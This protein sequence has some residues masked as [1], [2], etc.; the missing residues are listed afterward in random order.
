[1]D[2]ERRRLTLFDLGFLVAAS[3]LAM[4][5]MGW[6]YLDVRWSNLSETW[7][8]TL[9][10][11]GIAH[12][13]LAILA[14]EVAYLMPSILALCICLLALRLRHPRPRRWRRIWSQPGMLAC[15]VIILVAIES[16]AIFTLQHS[17][18]L[19]SRTLPVFT[20]MWPVEQTGT[21]IVIVW[22]TLGLTGRWR[23]ERSWID[24]AGRG[25]ALLVVLGALCRGLELF[26]G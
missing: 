23:P 12:G 11:Y 18:A 20:E 2:P 9:K 3:G 17:A 6:L 4:A 15:A 21:A 14:G 13:I 24:R 10:E 22:A 8:W 5:A 19:G 16:L 1:M 7:R 25:I 26:F